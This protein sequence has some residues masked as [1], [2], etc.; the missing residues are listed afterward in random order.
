ME[1]E[2]SNDFAPLRTRGWKK[3]SSAAV[4]EPG[5]LTSRPRWRR[6]DTARCLDDLDRS[7]HQ[8]RIARGEATPTDIEVVFQTDPDMAAEQNRL[9]QH[10]E[11]RGPDP[12]RALDGVRWKKIAQCQ[13]ALGFAG[14]PPRTPRQSWK[15]ERPST[16]ASSM[17]PRVCSIC[18]ISKT[19]SS[20]FERRV[21]EFSAFVQAFMRAAGQLY[22]P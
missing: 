12:E 3:S 9:R 10:R 19:S 14:A 16:S 15:K 5:Q 22:D 2:L 1:I 20:V 17:S 4:I 21:R 11:S 18:P 13:H 6:H 7:C 8:F